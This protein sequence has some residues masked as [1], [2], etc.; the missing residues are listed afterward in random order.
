MKS[1]HQY[2]FHRSKYGAELL[3]DVIEL[4]EI[5]KYL[6][7]NPVHKLT[8]YDFTLITEGSVDLLLNGE[9]YRLYPGD[10]AYSIPGEV[11]DWKLNNSVKGYVLVFEEEFL[12]SFFKDPNFLR[13]F[14][15]LDPDRGSSKL[16]LLRGHYNRVLQLLKQIMVE[17]KNYREKDHHILRAM[18]YETLTLFNRVS[19][20]T[21]KTSTTNVTINRHVN[22]FTELVNSEFIYQ[23]NIQY[24]ADK[25]CI[26]TNYLNKVVQNKLGITA[27]HFVQRRVLQESKKMLNYT[28][29][30]VA[31]IADKLNFN[32]ASYFTRFFYKNTGITPTQYRKVK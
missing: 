9:K 27:K 7:K 29:L 31:E 25:L 30:S 24:Y 16:S 2:N 10:I 23:R 4:D 17:I 12:L 15:Y 6:N 22:R 28:T 32:T 3:I 18:L 21:N 13:N 11:W 20:S 1:I 19:S 5:R 8:Y 14:S 26:T